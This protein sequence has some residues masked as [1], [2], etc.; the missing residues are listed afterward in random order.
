MIE[1]FV[2]SMTGF[3][4]GSYS[5]DDVEIVTEIRAVNHRFLD[6]FIRLPKTYNCF[7]PQIRKIVS[8]K[9]SRGKFEITVTRSG[10]KGALMELSVDHDLSERYYAC[11]LELKNKFSL[12][13]EI[14]VSDMLT[15][16]EIISTAENLGG[17]EQEW[18]FVETSLRKA[19]NALDEMRKAEGL[20]LWGDVE[21]RLVSI[22]ETIDIL[23][24][25]VEQ[26]S[27]EA[28]TRLEKRVREVTGGLEIDDDR[29]LQELALIAERSDVSEELIRL[30]SHVD[31]FLTFGK[32]GSPLGRK[33]DFL[34]QELHR[35]VN[36]LGAKSAS[37]DI[38]AH[39]VN[40]KSE[41]EK[42]REQ[43][44]NIE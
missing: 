43:I 33:L 11:L 3:G 17:F 41:V 36:T 29:L 9:N 34:L 18:V 8:E 24:P 21:T 7:E 10:A 2:K 42:I 4:R 13:G 20:A 35:E 23:F 1:K 31:Q 16:K 25:L 14:S 28:R 39:V 26:T 6:M 37:T 44:Q 27:S 5:C 32:Q 12:A 38:S 19:L 40:I 22:G 15:M 30:R